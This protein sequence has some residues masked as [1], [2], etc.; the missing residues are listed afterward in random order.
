MLLS[1]SEPAELGLVRPTDL[2]AVEGRDRSANTKSCLPI[3]VQQRP[4]DTVVTATRR[5]GARILNRQ[6]KSATTVKMIIS[7]VGTIERWLSSPPFCDQREIETIPPAELDHYLEIFFRA[8]RKPNGLGYGRNYL[9]ALRSCL[10]RHL[11]DHNY[12]CSIIKSPHF[13]NSQQAFVNNIKIAKGVLH[14]RPGSLVG[15]RTGES[16]DCPTQSNDGL[17]NLD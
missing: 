2:L 3:D 12:P 14:H 16:L 7:S 5:I 10:E 4:K 6:S 15:N 8:G 9:A 17:P 13:Y 1:L 11:K